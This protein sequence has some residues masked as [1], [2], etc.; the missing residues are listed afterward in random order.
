MM[1]FLTSAKPSH[2]PDIV[3]PQCIKPF[4]CICSFVGTPIKPGPV[5]TKYLIWLPLITTGS[6]IGRQFAS[7]KLP[8]QMTT[9]P[10]S[11]FFAG[12]F[13]AA[14]P[15]SHLKMSS[16]LSNMLSAFGQYPPYEVEPHEIAFPS[17][18]NAQKAPLE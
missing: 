16:T 18:S 4:S 17:P 5:L 9:S 14:N 2:V 10:T 12:F 15:M 1:I 11:P 3:S 6:S 13:T 8:P 7:E